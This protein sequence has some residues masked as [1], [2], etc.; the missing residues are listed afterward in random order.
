MLSPKFLYRG[1]LMEKF[2]GQQSPVDDY[3]LAESLSYFLWED[4]PD[5]KLMDLAMTGELHKKETLKEQVD[6]MLKSP[7]SISLQKASASNG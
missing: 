1:L 7:K 3:E 2:P 6:R 5:E 4:R